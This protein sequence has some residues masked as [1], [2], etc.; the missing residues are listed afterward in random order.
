MIGEYAVDP[1]VLTDQNILKLS[2]SLFGFSKGRLISNF[3]PKWD[4]SIFKYYKKNAKP[5][6][7]TIICER[8]ALLKKSIITTGRYFDFNNNWYNNASREHSLDPFHALICRI[9]PEGR[10]EIIRPEDL[11]ELH[12]L[13]TIDTSPCINR[14][15]TEMASAISSL[16]KLSTKVLFIDPHFNR[17]NSRHINPFLKFVELLEVRHRNLPYQTVQYHSG[18]D[19]N[20][21]LQDLQEKLVKRLNSRLPLSF[22]Q[23][24]VD[25]LH[26][27]YILTNIGGVRFG[28][29]LDEDQDG[30]KPEDEVCL[31]SESTYKKRWNDFYN[32]SLTPVFKCE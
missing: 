32:P 3:P 25:N 19:N 7:L 17:L 15:A 24:P 11:S 6:E 9:N 13:L 31:L 18:D 1:V 16:L 30:S 10:G 23:H 2:I 28:I 14:S 5:K 27:R 4:T 29:G 22:Y 12:E 26:N 20:G 8:L 21:F